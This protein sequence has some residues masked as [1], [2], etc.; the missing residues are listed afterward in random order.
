[1]RLASFLP[2]LLC[3]P[4]AAQELVWEVQGVPNKSS[5]GHLESGGSMSIALGDLNGDGYDDLLQMA[6]AF[7]EQIPM[8]PFREPE[9]WF[10]SG[11]D[12]RVLRVWRQPRRSQWYRS[13]AATG[14]MDGDR[15]PDYVTTS[16]DGIVPCC[17]NYVVAVRSG[18][19]D[20]LLWKVSG[21][22]SN[23]FGLAVL[24]GLDLDGDSRP[25]LVVTEPRGGKYGTVWAY[26]N[27][28]KLLWKLAGTSQLAF[29]FQSMYTL[30]RIGD[31]DRDG[32]DDFLVGAIDGVAGRGAA[33]VISGRSGKVLVKGLA[34]RPGEPLGHAVDGCGDIDK[35]GVPDFVASSTGFFASGV[36]HV[37]SGKT[38]KLIRSLGSTS[39]SVVKSGGLDFDLDGVP[40]VV[41]GTH[42]WFGWLQGAVFVFSGRDGTILHRLHCLS[43]TACGSHYGIWLDVLAP[44]P[45]NPYPLISVC[46]PEY[47]SYTSKW[48]FPYWRGRAALLRGASRLYGASC[49]GSLREKPQI[50]IEDLEARGV[51]IHL[52][53]GAARSPAILFLGLSRSRWGNL[54]LPLSLDP[55]GFLGCK[56][57]TSIDIVAVAYDANAREHA[58][59]DVPVRLSSMGKLTLYAQWLSLG[60]RNLAPG[61]L[62]SGLEW[63][64]R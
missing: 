12:G 8:S 40:D 30:G 32:R 57:Y 64:S 5:V 3:C 61:G 41:V 49:Q 15:I 11:K 13:G 56:L 22:I 44:Q 45:G 36:V 16:K 42:G 59:F 50:D 7:R 23:L 19:D 37:F 6:M 35:D 2:V 27:K 9:L 43:H 28:G 31:L 1:M 18:K 51:R 24:G 53:R 26:S 55:F 34:R 63:R 60:R 52:N 29:V 4:V 33:V 20:R 48:V 17:K 54:T 58:Y 47:G 21:L 39:G 10:L 38:G 46:Q 25:D 62:T 14:D